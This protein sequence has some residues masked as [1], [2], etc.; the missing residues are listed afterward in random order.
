MGRNSV[1]VGFWGR[2]TSRLRF[3]LAEDSEK[4]VWASVTPQ[5]SAAYDSS[6]SS[7]S[8]QKV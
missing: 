7:S 4:K 1:I 2:L 8:R 6:S 5:D 3:L